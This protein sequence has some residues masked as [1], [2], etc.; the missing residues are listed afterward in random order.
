MSAAIELCGERIELRADRSAFWPRRQT[1]IVADLHFGKADTF[2]A[3]GI[4][5]PGGTASTL[6]RLA[7]A[8]DRTGATRLVVLGDFWHARSGRTPGIMSELTDWRIERPEVQIEVVKGNHD[9]AG[10]PPEAWSGDWRSDDVADGPFVYRHH[11]ESS[12]VGYVLAG[13]LHPAFRLFGAGRQTLS[14]PCF[15]L[16]I[17]VAVLPAFGSF[18]GTAN[19]RPGVEDRVYVIAD[20][21]VIPVPA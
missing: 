15:W 3:E 14:L 11:P 2:R 10:L 5:V 1:L 18:T 7:T 4:A 16:G 6:A 19:V 17:R 20:D 8:L 21:E 9:R 13:H 12:E